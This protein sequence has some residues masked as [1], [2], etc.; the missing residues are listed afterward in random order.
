MDLTE[1]GI[2]DFGLRFGEVEGYLEAPAL[3]APARGHRRRAGAGRARAG[4]QVRRARAGHGGQEPG[5]ARLR[6]ARRL[7]HEPR[8]RHLRPR[9]LPHA[10]LPD[11]RR[12]PRA[13]RCRRTA[14]R[15]R[16]SRSSGQ[17][18]RRL[19]RRRTSAPSSSA[20]SGATSGRS[21]PTRSAQML[22]ARLEARVHRGR[23]HA[24]SASASGTWAG[25]STCARASSRTTCRRSSTRTSTPSPTAPSAGKAI[26]DRGLQGRSAGVL[27]I[28]AAGTRTACP[29]RPSWPRS[30]S[31]CASKAGAE[32][33]ENRCLT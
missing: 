18:G 6:P 12:D 29:P 23:D 5:A 33:K 1:K 14:W 22:Q 9:R 11:R 17:R 4:R 2:K 8:L 32:T 24:R 7:R 13:A 10:H 21:T 26:G 28:C 27:P 19:H 30:A 15:A 16:P 20:A 25:S 3:I 31:T